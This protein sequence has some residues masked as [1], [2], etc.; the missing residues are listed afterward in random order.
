MPSS[1]SPDSP[2]PRVPT[3]R[4]RT[5]EVERRVNARSA[6]AARGGFGDAGQVRQLQAGEDL[7]QVR[8]ID[9]LQP[10]ALVE[11]RRLFGHPDRGRHTD[12]AGDAF[13]DLLAD[14]ALH[15]DTDAFPSPL[16]YVRRSRQGHPG[17]V[18]WHA[19]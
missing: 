17:L 13:A 2:T 14:G 4:R 3:G 8:V 7:N 10:I 19:E 18:D 9:A 1:L 5:Q 12:R 15:C 6:Q 16:P 11:V